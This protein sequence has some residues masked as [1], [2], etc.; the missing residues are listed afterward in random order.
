MLKFRLISNKNG[1]LVYEYYPEGKM[2]PGKVSYDTNND[3]IKLLHLSEC[4]FTNCRMY[5]R[6]MVSRIRKMSED[7]SYDVDGKVCWY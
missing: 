6:H 4:E 1:I 7:N 2:S 3:E 5:F